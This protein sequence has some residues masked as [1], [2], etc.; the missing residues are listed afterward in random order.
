MMKWEKIFF[1]VNSTSIIADFFLIVSLSYKFKKK[2]KKW[3]ILQLNIN[4][5]NFKESLVKL[6]E[7]LFSHRERV[8]WR[9]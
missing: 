1:L 7:I 6:T 4:I 5:K 8:I 2:I 3:D 9:K